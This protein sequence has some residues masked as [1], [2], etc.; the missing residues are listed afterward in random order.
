MDWNVNANQI[1][2]SSP[3]ILTQDKTLGWYGVADD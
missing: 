3:K 2:F 1:T